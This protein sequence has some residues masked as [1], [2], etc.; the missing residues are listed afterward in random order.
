MDNNCFSLPQYYIIES[1][2]LCNFKCPICPNSIKRDFLK[3]YM[4]FNL[5]EHI[6]SQIKY[7]AKVI[8]LYW[9][10]EPLLDSSLVDKIVMCKKR[11][12]AKVILSTNGSL[13]SEKLVRQLDDA[14]LD[15]IIISVDACE[16]QKIYS[17]IR[18]GGNIKKLNKNIEVLLEYKGNIAVFLQ[19]IDMYVNKSEKENFLKKW[20]LSDCK[21][22]VSCLFTWSNQIPA[23]KIASDELSPVINKQR[24]PC[25]DLWNKMAIHWNGDVSAC[26]FDYSDSLHLGNCE[27]EMLIDIWNGIRARKLRE[28]HLSGI[29]PGIC[30]D[31][32]AWAEIGEYEAMYHLKL[33][34]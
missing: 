3:G 24:Q 15:E 11:T 31:C 33:E 22:E 20:E 26:C 5:L 21:T 9:L 25:A 10:G 14:G 23:L 2:N 17:Q 18:C 13:L 1:T 19:F 7:R 30:K 8:Q 16:N 28:E 27:E 6:L 34:G 29:Y 32:D 4:N 12:D